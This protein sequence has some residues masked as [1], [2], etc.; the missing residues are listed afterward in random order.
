[1]LNGGEQSSGDRQMAESQLSEL[2]NMRVLLEEARG[3]SR[4]LS[5]HRR[6]RLEAR[7]G[8]ALE[9]VERQIVQLRATKG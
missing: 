6:A 4:T 2:Q 3:L 9:E 1:M 8:E 5:Y 7:I